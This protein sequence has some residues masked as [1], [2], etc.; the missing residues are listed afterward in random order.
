MLLHVHAGAVGQQKVRTIPKLLD[1][2]ENVVPPTTVETGGMLAQFVEYLVH[3]KRSEDGLNQHGRANCAARNV[4]FILCKAKY[5]IP[6]AGFEMILQLR[7]VK[8]W[9]RTFFDEASCIM[10]EVESEI[11]QRS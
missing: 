11:E 9:A 1:E 2:T 4:Q 6:E 5:V 3:V 8:I 10:K 7:Q